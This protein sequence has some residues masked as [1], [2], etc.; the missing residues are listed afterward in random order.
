[1]NKTTLIIGIVLLL[2]VIFL[3]VLIV[4]FKNKKKKNIINNLDK[5]NTEKN[6]I[7]SST[8]ITDLDKAEKLANNKKLQ[9]DVNDWKKRFDE[10]E[11]VDLPF[12]TDELVEAETACVN[13]DYDQ[14]NTLLLNAEKDIFHVKAKSIKLL[15]EIK[16]LTESEERNR[17]TVTKLKSLY[18]EVVFKYNK[19]KNDYTGVNT[20]IELQFENIDKLFSAFEVAIQKKNYDE[21]GRIVKALDDMINNINIVVEEAPTILLI[22]NMILPKKMKDIE[23]IA[24]KL[25]RDGYNIEY[26]NIEY[27]I[28]E[29]NKKI[30][31][32]LDRL[33]VLN[34]Q[35][36]I[37]D[38]KTLVDYY[39]KIYTDFDNEKRGKREYERGII[40]VG[41]R[42][43][44][45]SSIVR[46]LY[47]E[48]DN[49]KDTY[50]LSNEEIKV[51]D[52]INKDLLEVKESFKLINDRTL[53]RVMPYSKLNNE[54]EL[55]AVNLSKVEDKLETTLKNLGSL[56]ED[57]ARAR[58]Q[59]FEIK[60]I[61]NNS[62]YKIKDYNLPIIP[63][64][65]YVELKEAV[66]AI[67]EINKEIE[68]K[69]ISIRTLN[70]R[71]DTAQDLA[72][73]L[74]QTAS[75]ATK[76]AAMAEMAIVYGNRYRSTNREVELGLIAST[77]AFNKGN[78]KESLE[79]ILNALNIVEPGIHKKLLS[80]MES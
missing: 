5:L 46:N 34:L 28:A 37:F 79:I 62:K 64:K 16:D 75:S 45:M 10:L 13:A 53:A 33:K 59:L 24:Q 41:E 35:D 2:L 6:L 49:I 78:Y 30:S 67:G 66:D 15:S 9:A 57:E 1:M 69:P 39:E 48:I 14:A 31:E 51:V 61:I 26:L 55:V 58:E 68:K 22:S 44:K 27:N 25:K 73:K 7:I 4:A 36:S 54:C 72:L 12:L 71:V 17:E 40:N 18:R 52:E 19:H 8:L 50:D 11:K 20:P 21:F 56:K 32:I 29:T 42:L 80:K 77:K 38:L 23:N 43:N 63:E 65:F 3:T 70:L 47:S 74:Y 76:T 60:N